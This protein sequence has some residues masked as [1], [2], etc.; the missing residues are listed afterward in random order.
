MPGR[1]ERSDQA[2]CSDSH[3]REGA[4]GL[5]GLAMVSPTSQTNPD[6]SRS[7]K[8]RSAFWPRAGLLAL[9]LA[10]GALV[11]APLPAA[12]S[13][14]TGPATTSPT[15]EY[16][17]A[18]GDSLALGYDV[19]TGQGYTDDLFAHY[20]A[21]I[22]SLQKVDLGCD[23]ETA[24]T[25]ISGN[26]SCS[27][28][29]ATELATAEAFLSSHPNQVAFVTINV[30]TGLPLSCFSPG[31]FTLI[32]STCVTSVIAQG[33]TYLSTILAGL[34]SAAGPSVPIVGMTVPDP[35]VVEWLN[36]ASGQQLAQAVSDLVPDVEPGTVGDLRQLR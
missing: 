5:G 11:S 17:L 27:Y 21:A 23:G 33:T 1:C 19:P 32:S 9:G 26:P 36:G 35:F 6:R 13:G 30:G 3:R 2:L 7:P 12:A 18:L 4:M 31:T 29:P 15:T 34:R 24:G 22:P 28:A 16:Y 25:F 8:R 14:T 10:V 20:G